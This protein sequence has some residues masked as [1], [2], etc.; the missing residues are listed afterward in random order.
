MYI[1]EVSGS[2]G[3]CFGTAGCVG[4]G[5]GAD[6]CDGCGLGAADGACS[7]GTVGGDGV[8]C[9]ATGGALETAG[10]GVSA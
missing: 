9:V 10:S 2:V 4:A 8:A 1:V 5:A 6:A 3:E 7:G